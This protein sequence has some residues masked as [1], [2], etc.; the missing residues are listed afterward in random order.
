MIHGHLRNKLNRNSKQRSAL[1]KN[2]VRSFFKNN[3]SISTTL[4]RAKVIRVTIEKMIT[5][6][7]RAISGTKDKLSAIKSLY[8]Y[9]DSKELVDNVMSVGE[10]CIN[11]HGGYTRVLKAGYRHGDNA[12]RAYILLVD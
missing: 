8:S 4:M 7:R 10:K 6:A 2:M 12:C 9:L 11:R 3:G 1:I 5:V